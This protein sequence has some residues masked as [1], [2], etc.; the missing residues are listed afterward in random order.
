ML[1]STSES[2]PSFF[3]Q[4]FDQRW[5]RALG[6]G[7]E[8]HDSDSLG[9][10]PFTSSIAAT[11][12]MNMH[13]F[14]KSKI[15]NTKTV[16]ARKDTIEEKDFACVLSNWC[17]WKERLLTEFEPPHY[18]HFRFNSILA[19]TKEKCDQ[20]RMAKGRM[21]DQGKH[22][23]GDSDVLSC[24]A[25]HRDMQ[26]CIYGR[27]VQKGG[28]GSRRTMSLL[29]TFGLMRTIYGREGHDILG[30]ED[31]CKPSCMRG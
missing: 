14:S 6:D 9:Y 8:T 1:G 5:K 4:P 31:W 3:P 17:D 29:P 2:R 25:L 28:D 18:K 21:P 12:T 19:P 23:E 11:S 15:T 27:A 26:F 16:S 24:E 7:Q 30:L 13:A 20:M 10:A 22:K